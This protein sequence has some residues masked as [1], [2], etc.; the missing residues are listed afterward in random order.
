MVGGRGFQRQ[1]EDVVGEFKLY[2]DLQFYFRRKIESLKRYF[3]ELEYRSV[4][5][6]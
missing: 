3:E 4:W 1:D 2:K 6:H 5:S